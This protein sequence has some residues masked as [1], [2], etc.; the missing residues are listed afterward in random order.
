MITVTHGLLKAPPLLSKA[1]DE[2]LLGSEQ[3][4]HR[5]AVSAGYALLKSFCCLAVVARGRRLVDDVTIQE[6]SGSLS[7][8]ARLA[9]E[10]FSLLFRLNLTGTPL[11]WQMVGVAR[12][13][14]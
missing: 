5:N 9:M 4:C 11:G 13:P 3:M 8:T 6:E 12:L 10:A 7:G 2:H 14:Q 1:L